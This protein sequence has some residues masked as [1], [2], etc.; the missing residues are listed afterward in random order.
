M[1]FSHPKRLRLS[2]D[3][4][5]RNLQFGDILKSRMECEQ[6]FLVVT[7]ACDLSRDD[8]EHIMLLHGKLI[9]LQPRDWSYRDDNVAR[10]PIMILQNGQR[11]WI[12]WKL[13]AVESRHRDD[14][15]ESLRQ[16]GQLTRIARLREAYAIQLQQKLLARMG[17]IGLPANL[18]VPFP[19]SVSL[20]Y[21]DASGKARELDIG[22]VEPAS[23]YVGRTDES[24]RVQH[25][26]LTEQTCDWIAQS[27]QD[28]N[29][30]SVFKSVRGSLEGIKGDSEFITKFE[31]GQ[32]E[33]P[34]KNGK[35][36]IESG[37]NGKIY[38]TVIWNNDLVEGVSIKA[39]DYK[40]S[41]IIVQVTDISGEGGE[42][43]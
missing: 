38:A 5:T 7:P 6:V 11:K 19:I 23:C 35:K 13:K 3:T 43:R 30:E 36:F 28:L 39:R 41:A 10:T 20:F 33:V 25:L 24:K 17:R 22:N 31:R 26:V 14:L 2:E 12:K 37:D 42:L 16:E 9:D 4:G 15:K 21:I 40:H 29:E 1:I 32:V 34:D 27:L 8:V 18:P